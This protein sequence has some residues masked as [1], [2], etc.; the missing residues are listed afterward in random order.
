M[1][2][3]SPHFKYFTEQS[4][5]SSERRLTRIM[6]YSAIFLVAWIKTKTN[7]I[8]N[9][10]IPKT[11]ELMFLTFCCYTIVL[12]VRAPNFLAMEK[13]KL[14]PH[15]PF[16]ENPPSLLELRSKVVKG[17]FRSCFYGRQTTQRAH[18]H[19]RFCYTVPF[20]SSQMYTG[21]WPSKFEKKKH[22][23]KLWKVWE[24]N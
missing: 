23:L 2:F 5:N 19:H 20:C 22:Y 10:V 1:L 8:K 16:S 9:Y 15:F 13:N 11:S 12:C 21:K 24:K 4:W 17:V 14:K 3:L 7:R 6:R 18:Y